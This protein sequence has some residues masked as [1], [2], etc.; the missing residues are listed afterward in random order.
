MYLDQGQNPCMFVGIGA[1]EFINS[2]AETASGRRELL[3]GVV[4]APYFAKPVTFSPFLGAVW[5][6]AI[7]R[8][9]AVAAPPNLRR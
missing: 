8:H 3:R 4:S 1:P 5:H 6:P 2:W 9:A 7:T